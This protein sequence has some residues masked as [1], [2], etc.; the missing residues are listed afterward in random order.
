MWLFFAAEKHWLLSTCCHISIVVH[1]FSIIINFECF[2]ELSLYWYCK[3]LMKKV[4]TFLYLQERYFNSFKGS[5][6]CKWVKKS[7]FFFHHYSIAYAFRNTHVKFQAGIRNIVEVMNFF[8]TS[9]STSVFGTENFKR[10]FL[11]TMFFKLA[12][13]ITKEQL[14]IFQ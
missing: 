9:C 7:I 14:D 5:F 11:E 8:V 1:Y 12:C 2:W 4:S 6:S 3:K 10:V 13:T